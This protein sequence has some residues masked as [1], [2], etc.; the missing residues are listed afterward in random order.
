VFIFHSD[1]QKSI[2][3]KVL[4]SNGIL[5]LQ[6]TRLSL[7]GLKN[8]SL[9]LAALNPPA[10]PPAPSPQRSAFQS[11]VFSLCS[12]KA[13]TNRILPQLSDEQD[14][15]RSSARLRWRSCRSA[16]L[17]TTISKRAYFLKLKC[18]GEE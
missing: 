8:L 11:A 16:V 6:Q 3:C 2:Y 10:H 18:S 5:L 1:P 9:F 13:I 17:N 7:E 15:S 14:S 4:K 12:H